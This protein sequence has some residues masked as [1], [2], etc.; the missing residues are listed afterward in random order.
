MA[1]QLNRVFGGPESERTER[2]KA[3]LL[4]AALS[5]LVGAVSGVLVSQSYWGYYAHRPDVPREISQARQLRFVTPLKSVGWGDACRLEIDPEYS[6]QD[7]MK[8][9]RDDPYY[10]HEGRLLLPLAER[11][12]SPVA[13]ARDNGLAASELF[14]QL[15]E[16]GTLVAGDVGYDFAMCL[17]GVAVEVTDGGGQPAIVVGLHGQQVSN[18]HYPYY[19]ASFRRAGSGWRL[20]RSQLYFYDVAGIEGLETPG[21]AIVFT[22]LTFTAACGVAIVYSAT[23][24]LAARARRRRTMR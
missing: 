19:E 23:T 11:G 16:A 15:R 8:W 4:T 14:R 10:A 6:V 24:G 7:R 2:M 3:I 12:M 17:A 18:D 1:L 9:A 13:T 22:I 20:D 21:L 5:L